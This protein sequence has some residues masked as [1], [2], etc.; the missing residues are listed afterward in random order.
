MGIQP[1]FLLL[2]RGNNTFYQEMKKL[3]RVISSFNQSI[4]R[5]RDADYEIVAT[6]KDSLWG[7]RAVV[8]DPDGHSVEI[9][10]PIFR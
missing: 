9:T 1:M 7:R 5:L 8:K 4:A 10:S 2:L 3:L 6:P